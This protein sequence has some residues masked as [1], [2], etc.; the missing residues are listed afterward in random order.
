MQPVVAP[1]V[2]IASS[3]SP[4]SSSA[5]PPPHAQNV[6]APRSY[7]GRCYQAIHPVQACNLGGLALNTLGTV[8]G[9]AGGILTPNISPLISY[10]LYG[11]AAWCAFHLAVEGCDVHYLRAWRPKKSL[12]ETVDATTAA[13]AA[14]KTRVSELEHQNSALANIRTDL[15]SSIE[16]EKTQN[17]T[18]TSTLQQHENSLHELTSRTQ[19]LQQSL[20]QT[21]ALRQ[22]WQSVAQKV[23]QGAA[24]FDAEIS[25]I[26]P[27]AHDTEA[28]IGTL[29]QLTQ[30][31]SMNVQQAQILA[32]K[33]EQARSGW[34]TILRDL[35]KNFS[36]IKDDLDI[37]AR[38]LEE[39]KT[40]NDSL[41]QTNRQLQD[42]TSRL[43]PMIQQFQELVQQYQQAQARFS[44]AKEK[45]RCLEHIPE[46]S[47][48]LFIQNA[49]QEALTAL[50]Q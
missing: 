40:L 34:I 28:A 33:M 16:Q 6:A 39:Q 35:Q 2:S 20:E 18:L 47:T 41:Q 38:Q 17:A 22:E 49:A 50:T 19:L 21:M 36:S 11:F 45:L 32:A 30:D 10:G 7:E 42:S 24:S 37:K 8:S 9:V 12:E 29:Q 5:L 4:L 3:D 27:A 48:L 1:Q 15:E 46:G 26:L 13:V 25:H 23:A 14:L 44:R 43:T 31:A